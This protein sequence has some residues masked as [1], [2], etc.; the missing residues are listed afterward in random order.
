MVSVNMY[1]SHGRCLLRNMKTF[2]SVPDIDFIAMENRLALLLK[3]PHREEFFSHSM[4][5]PKPSYW[6]Y[7][8]IGA[9]SLGAGAVLAVTGGLAAPILL[10]AVGVYGGVTAVTTVGVGT[11]FAVGGSV[12]GAAGAGLAGYKMTRRTR[13]LSDFSFERCCY[14]SDKLAVMIVISGWMQRNDD[15]K[16]TYGILPS[17]EYITLEE[18]LTRYYT[19]ICLNKSIDAVVRLMCEHRLRNVK[20]ETKEWNKKSD[21]LLQ[22]YFNELKDIFGVD[23]RCPEALVAPLRNPCMELDSEQLL[24]LAVA[25]LYFKLTPDETLTRTDVT[26]LG[27]TTVNLSSPYQ[28]LELQ[29]DDLGES[30]DAGAGSGTSEKASGKNE[31]LRDMHW[32]WSEI[33]ESAAYELYLLRW[34]VELQIEL[35]KSVLKLIESLRNALATQVVATALLGA[36]ATA[37]L[38]PF[39]ILQFT[40]VIDGTWTLAVERA[41]LAGQELAR[42]LLLRPHGTR[43]VTLVGNSMGCRVIVEAIMIIFQM[44]EAMIEDLED[45]DKLDLI[46]ARNATEVKKSWFSSE[47]KSAKERFNIPERVTLADFDNLIQDVVLLGTPYST[48]E[49]KWVRIRSIVAGRVVNGYSKKDLV[50]AIVYRYERWKLQVAGLTAINVSGIENIDLSDMIENHTDYCIKMKEILERIGLSSPTSQ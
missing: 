38:L 46:D 39:T 44:K 16:R 34:E 33:E 9:A 47:R 10:A 23:P 7:A 3:C 28:K 13:G 35:G 37:A 50:L 31:I 40:D 41:E 42:V 19:R 17:D 36:L 11:A 4:E 2:L 27:M 6:R 43:A 21:E 1:D 48:E 45:A 29:I 24:H 32:D 14:Q 20:K 5:K 30:E 26:N 15:D 25:E 49:D 12:F 18:R 8:K 22:A